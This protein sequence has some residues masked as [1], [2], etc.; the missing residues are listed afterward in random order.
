MESAGHDY[1]GRSIRG[2]ADANNGLKIQLV[3][4]DSPAG[5]RAATRT[6]TPVA[7]A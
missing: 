1:V 2:D 7:R 6:H 4:P 3:A 5:L